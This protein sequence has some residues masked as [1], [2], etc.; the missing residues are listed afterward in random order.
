MNKKHFLCTLL[1]LSI[2]LTISATSAYYIVGK[3]NDYTAP[4]YMSDAE[5]EKFAL[6]DEDGDS[7][8]SLT[9]NIPK[10]QFNFVLFEGIA[11][12]ESEN[13]YFAAKPFEII[14]KAEIQLGRMPTVTA[15]ITCTNWNGGE[16]QLDLDARTLRL[17]I[18]YK[19]IDYNDILYLVGAPTGYTKPSIENEDK[20]TN[21]KFIDAD[22]DGVYKG[23]FTIPANCFNFC[24]AK[25]L[26]GDSTTYIVPNNS[27]AVKFDFYGIYEGATSYT[28]S[29]QYWTNN[30]WQSAE[31]IEIAYDSNINTIFFSCE[32]LEQ[33]K[34]LYLIGTPSGWSGPNRGNE[35]TLNKWR[36]ANNEENE[37]VYKG[38]FEIDNSRQLAFRFYDA[39]T[40][41]D[42]GGSYGC[43][44]DETIFHYNVDENGI[45]RGVIKKGKGSWGFKQWPSNKLYAEVDLLNMSVFFANR[46]TSIEK[47]K[48]VDLKLHK[49]LNNLYYIESNDMN[50]SYFVYNMYG[51]SVMSGNEK[52]INLN[53]LPSGMYLINILNGHNAIVE[54]IIITN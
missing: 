18:M 51:V 42:G 46:K 10:N 38:E 1:M 39:L 35:D 12:W 27:E 49:G 47:L 15:N 11:G 13:Y 37:N 30:N 34:Y 6:T 43:E 8:Y 48:E 17:K 16:V 14:D 31:D 23:S 22:G 21:A 54:K 28:Q 36:L 26:N 19:S 7:I 9:I 32:S 4:T 50:V 44:I 29:L 40:G 24:L 52:E 2:K 3:I 41:W 45:Y 53:S 33:T 25:G 20:F 5:R